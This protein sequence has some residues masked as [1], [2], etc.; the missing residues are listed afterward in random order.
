MDGELPSAAGIAKV[1]AATVLALGLGAWAHK[2]LAPGM[3]DE[4]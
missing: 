2:K 1:V 3:V 4:L